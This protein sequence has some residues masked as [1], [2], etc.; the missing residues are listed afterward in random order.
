MSAKL[1]LDTAAMAE[2]FFADTALT[3][4]VCALPVYRFVWLLNEK[5]DMDFVRKPDMDIML[6]SSKGKEHF[7]SVYQYCTPLNGCQHIMYQ[8]KSEKEALLPEVKQLDYL[9][10]IQSATAAE[11]ARKIAHHMRDI[12]EIQLAQ[13]L[14]ADKLKSHNNLLV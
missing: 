4:I 8:L 5:L 14:Q 13:L 1:V 10:L 12:G 3:G 11:D 7:F 2:D 6:Q 9:W